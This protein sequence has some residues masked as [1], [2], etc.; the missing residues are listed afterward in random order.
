M[1]SVSL[2]VYVPRLVEPVVSVQV[3]TDIVVDLLH[4]PVHHRTVSVHFVR[5]HLLDDVKKR[6]K[7]LQLENYTNSCYPHHRYE[8]YYLRKER[9]R[10]RGRVGQQAIETG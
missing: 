7:Q 5:L 2:Q 10:R 8:L 3:D 6:L 9:G 1:Q 4:L